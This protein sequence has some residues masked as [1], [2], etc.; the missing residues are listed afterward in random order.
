MQ[1]PRGPREGASSLIVNAE[2]G[3]LV[4]ARSLAPGSGL[5]RPLGRSFRR[6]LRAGEYQLTTLSSPQ[7]ALWVEW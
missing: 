3:L 7:V 4:G 6:T 5:A 1:G 2:P